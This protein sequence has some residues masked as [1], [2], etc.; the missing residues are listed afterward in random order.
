[1]EKWS[2]KKIKT[3]G[4]QLTDEGIEEKKANVERCGRKFTKEDL[5]HHIKIFSRITFSKAYIVLHG[6]NFIL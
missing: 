2:D 5:D 1:M 4:Y 6:S 3:L